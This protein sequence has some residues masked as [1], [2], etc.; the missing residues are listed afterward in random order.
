MR[1]AMDPHWRDYGTG[2]RAVRSTWL[3]VIFKVAPAH[4]RVSSHHHR[5]ATL[6]TV[7]DG[8][9][10]EQ[11]AD[12]T[13]AERRVGGI[14]CLP[15]G[16]RHALRIG[17]TPVR[18]LNLEL[19]IEALARVSD[20]ARVLVSRRYWTGHPAALWAAR[21]LACLSWDGPDRTLA[22]E[23]L[24]LEWLAALEPRATV[25]PSSPPAWLKRVRARLHAPTA[26]RNRIGGLAAEAGVDPAHLAR[27]FRRH[28]GT[29]AG[30]YAR[31]VRV[32]VACQRL[33]AGHD[34]LS[35]V[36]VALGF[37]DQSHLGRM[38]RRYVGLTPAA[39]RSTSSTF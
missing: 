39:L 35:E 26:E 33:S 16:E 22:L 1:T 17:P 4:L 28:Y 15:A 29:S 38:L 13:S 30:E 20:A 27:E 25:S 31:R 18:S 32:D 23:S 34:S 37:A 2:F 14:S 21:V 10:V 19:D 24:S 6:A 5:V 11:L 9:V 12:G 3:S 8:P 36:A 7:L